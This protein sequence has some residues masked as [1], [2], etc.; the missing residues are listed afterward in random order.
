MTD[1]SE[2]VASWE[3]SKHLP[4]IV[5]S[6]GRRQLLKLPP[7]D[8][9]VMRH[10]VLAG[11]LKF[12]NTY[13]ESRWITLEELQHKVQ[14]QFDYLDCVVWLV[15]LGEI[16]WQVIPGIPQIVVAEDG[17]PTSVS[18]SLKQ[19]HANLIEHTDSPHDCDISSVAKLE[20]ALTVASQRADKSNKGKNN[21]WEYRPTSLLNAVRL[22]DELKDLQHM[23]DVAIQV[24][25]MLLSPSLVEHLLNQDWFSSKVRTN[26]LIT[27]FR[28][29]ISML[30]FIHDSC[31]F[32]VVF[33]IFEVMCIS[34]WASVPGLG[35]VN[36]LG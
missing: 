30:I 18:S 3:L 7:A 9:Q 34:C 10:W 11:E 14:T 15:G 1:V 29:Q 31:Y 16:P 32:L 24:L 19:L 12:R 28:F 26:S 33:D 17:S 23:R 21:S 25:K 36:L 27:I 22:S 5:E 20:A 4:C 2:A 8:A 35:F 6:R 13:G